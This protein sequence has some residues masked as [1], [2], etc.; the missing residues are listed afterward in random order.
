[1][2]GKWKNGTSR[3]AGEDFFFVAEVRPGRFSS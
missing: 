3:D 2:L 1:M